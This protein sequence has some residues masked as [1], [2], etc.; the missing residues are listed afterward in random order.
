MSASEHRCAVNL[1]V[2]HHDAGAPGEIG[3]SERERERAIGWALQLSLS[4]SA[5]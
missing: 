2:R 4:R 3:S 5:I 1:R